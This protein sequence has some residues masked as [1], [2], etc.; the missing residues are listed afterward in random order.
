[1]KELM[2]Q[3]AFYLLLIIAAI[4]IYDNRHTIANKTSNIAK[5][6]YQSVKHVFR[7]TGDA[8]QK[9]AQSGYF[10]VRRYY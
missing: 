8:L 3:C 7:L 6:S 5:K 9:Q 10:H 4:S 2:K 1:M